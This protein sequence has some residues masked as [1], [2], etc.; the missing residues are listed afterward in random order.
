LRVG[1]T[2]L[3]PVRSNAA[4]GNTTIGLAVSKFGRAMRVPVTT[5][6]SSDWLSSAFAGQ[7]LL[8]PTSVSQNPKDAIRTGVT[9]NPPRELKSPRHRLAELLDI[10][11]LPF[12]LCQ[13]R[14]P[15]SRPRPRSGPD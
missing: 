8:I 10:R 1:S 14:P 4:A 15:R 11:W 7:W 5:I 12:R 3:D 6:S 13:A 9:F 2:V